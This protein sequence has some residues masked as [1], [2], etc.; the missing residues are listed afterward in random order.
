MNNTIAK[1]VTKYRWV[2]LIVIWLLYIVNY[3]DRLTVTTFL[4]YIG[5][6]LHLN[7]VQLGWLGSIFFLGYSFAQI[8]AGFTAD[9]IGPKK[10]MSIAIITFTFV[11]F[12]TGL[13]QSFGQFIALRLALAFGEGHHFSPSIKTIA[14]W[15]P[16]SERGRAAGWFTTSWAVA[17]AITPV[18]VTTLAATFF[19]GAWR[20][21]FYLMAIPGLLG[22][23]LLWKFMINTPKEALEIGKISTEE[24]NHINEGEPTDEHG[25]VLTGVKYSPKIFF[26]DPVFYVFCFAWFAHLMVYWGMTTWITT[27]LVK[28]HGLNIKTMGLFAALPYFM[29]FIA[30]NLG[31][32]LQDKVFHGKIRLLCVIAFGGC[33]PVMWALGAVPKGSNGLL[34]LCLALGGFMVTL[35]SSSINGFPALRYPKEIVGRATGISNSVGQFG[36]FLSPLLAGYLVITLPNGG[37]NFGNVFIFWALASLVAAIGICFL[38]ERPR[39]GEKYVI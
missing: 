11:T 5:K 12:I 37:Y 17:P 39:E 14:T 13:V 19:A 1:K 28:Q 7:A 32:F 9:R 18:I 29:A 24:Y 21:V 16:L 2:I 20:P 38:N 30:Q 15:F 27:F 23:L 26:H 10:T 6:D 22:I 33:A 25:N 36:S 3:M 35:S 8:F 4:P 34:L 31:G